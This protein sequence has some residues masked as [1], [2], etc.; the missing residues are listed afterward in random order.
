VCVASPHPWRSAALH[1]I[2]SEAPTALE[3]HKVEG[4]TE[5][6]LPPFSQYAALVFQA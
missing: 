5:F 1:V 6:H 3:P 4:L 2:G